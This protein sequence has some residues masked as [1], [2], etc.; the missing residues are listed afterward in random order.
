MF[1]GECAGNRIMLFVLT[2]AELV[3]IAAS[4]SRLVL[5]RT[6]VS[7]A[8]TYKTRQNV[9]HGKDSENFM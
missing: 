1:L 4:A 8:A 5:F 2:V 7:I 9:L 6:C 3:T